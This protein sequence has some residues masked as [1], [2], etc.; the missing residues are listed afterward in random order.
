MHRWVTTLV[1]CVSVGACAGPQTLVES[2]D[3]GVLAAAATFAINPPPAGT[4]GATTPHEGTRL[5]EAI[6]G[7][8]AQVLKSKGYRQVDPPAA[9]LV[10]TYRLVFMGRVNRDD[11]E[12]VIAESRV[13]SGPGD[14]YGTY[15]P[16]PETARGERREMLLVTIADRKSS[17]VVWQATNEGLATG[18]SAAVSEV[19]RATR[20]TLAR[21]PHSRTVEP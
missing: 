15:H 11:R 13:A 17:M 2:A 10:V 20:A 6:E 12:D 16:I 5:R 21:L 19:S 4:T 3:L 18:T 8:I 1:F 9:D 7:E 14:P